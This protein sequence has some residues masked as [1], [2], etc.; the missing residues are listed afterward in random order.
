MSAISHAAD[1][2]AVEKTMLETEGIIQS[3][4]DLGRKRLKV[5]YNATITSFSAISELLEG[6]GFPPDESWWNRTKAG[7]YAYLDE[8][9]RSNARA[10]VPPC[11][12]KPPK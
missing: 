10:P 2:M 4:M 7:W 3:E 9:A 1:A 12:N 5:L 8:N 6:I 11:C